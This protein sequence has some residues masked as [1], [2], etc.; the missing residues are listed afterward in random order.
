MMY[1]VWFYYGDNEIFLIFSKKSKAVDF[2]ANVK[3]ALNTRFG[4]N[5]VDYPE[6]DCYEHGFLV[7]NGLQAVEIEEYD[8]EDEDE[9]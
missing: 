7:L 2:V 1:R 4:P 3:S 5:T 9:I 6:K 8:D